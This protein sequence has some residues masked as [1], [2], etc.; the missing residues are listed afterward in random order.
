MD[1]TPYTL[2]PAPC[3]LHP[4][5]DTR[6]SKPQIPNPHPQTPNQ[7]EHEHE[8]A[9]QKKQRAAPG[10]PM[11]GSD[12]GEGGGGWGRNPAEEEALEKMEHVVEEATDYIKSQRKKP[13]KQSTDMSLEMT[14]FPYTLNK[15]NAT[16]WV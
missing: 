14:G 2:H 4:A 10:A 8:G 7:V 6:S 3:T 13:L 1:P 16:I 15:K 5:P 12:A 9:E 11:A